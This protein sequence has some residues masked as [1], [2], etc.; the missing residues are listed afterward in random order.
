MNIFIGFLFCAWLFIIFS[1][2]KKDNR[3][4]SGYRNNVKPNYKFKIYFT[5]I[6][7]LIII[8][9]SLVSR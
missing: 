9:Y 5:I 2:P 8:L 3:F 1:G 7:W 4:S 6:V